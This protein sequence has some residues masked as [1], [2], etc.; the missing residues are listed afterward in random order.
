MKKD[1]DK[2]A[3]FHA[4][5]AM[6][7]QV[8]LTIIYTIMGATVILACI[9]PIVWAGALAYVIVAVIKTNKGEP[10]KYLLVADWFCKAEYAAA[11]P[12][13]AAK[14]AQEAPQQPQQQPPQQQ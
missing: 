10:F 7:F 12:A 2:Y 9:A 5:Q 3:A 6:C 1:E 11:Y 8:A 14:A 4:K 13:E